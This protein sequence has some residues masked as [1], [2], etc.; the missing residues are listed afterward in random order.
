MDH[1]KAILWDMLCRG[2]EDTETQMDLLGDRNQ[3]MTLDQTL[4]FI[5]AKEARKGQHLDYC[6][7]RQRMQWP[8]AHTRD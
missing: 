2:L 5:E 6:Y 7:H 3:D 1:T 8:A 4:K